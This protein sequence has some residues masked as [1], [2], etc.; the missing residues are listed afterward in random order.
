MQKMIY[1]IQIGYMWELHDY[2]CDYYQLFLFQN[3]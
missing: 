3:L 1:R 2:L